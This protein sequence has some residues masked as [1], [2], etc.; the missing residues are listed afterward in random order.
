MV[1]V[2]EVRV[3]LFSFLLCSSVMLLPLLPK[4]NAKVSFFIHEYWLYL[5]LC[6]GILSLAILRL[7]YRAPI[8]SQVAL[9]AGSIGFGFGLGFLLSLY[10]AP[11]RVFGWYMMVLCFFHFSEYFVTAWINPRSL[12]LDSFLLNHSV[13]YGI[14]VVAGITE[15]VIELFIIPGIKQVS[16]FSVVGLLIIIAGEGLR[17]LAMFT[18]RSNFN[19]IIQTYKERDHVLVTHGIYKY[20]R[21][22]SYVGWFIWTL[23]TQ[24]MLCNP[25]CLV[26]YTLASWRFF[27]ERVIE[28]EITLL[29]F[30]GEDY[31]DYQKAVPTGLPFIKGYRWEL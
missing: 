22:P 31:I 25:I 12:S 6:Y 30:F 24:L 1:V 29:N 15:Y 10:S 3:S 19:H 18:A 2:A 27:K 28:E 5:L 17:K 9:R 20:M 21:H 23:G 11:W 7:V 4:L 26:A 13:E 14:A 16:I 8:S